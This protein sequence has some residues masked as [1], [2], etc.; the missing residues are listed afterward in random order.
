MGTIKNG[1]LEGRDYTKMN[2]NFKDKSL[3][4]A[5]KIME[6]IFVNLKQTEEEQQ[7]PKETAQ[8]I[9]KNQLDIMIMFNQNYLLSNKENINE[10]VPFLLELLNGLYVNQGQTSREI[11]KKNKSKISKLPAHVKPIDCEE[12][13]IEAP[14][15]NNLYREALQS[16]LLNKR[17]EPKGYMHTF[18]KNKQGYKSIVEINLIDTNE[19][20]ELTLEDLQV[21]GKIESMF[22][23][24]KEQVNKKYSDTYSLTIKKADYANLVNK[25]FKGVRLQKIFKCLDNLDKFKIE[26]TQYN[27]YDDTEVEEGEVLFRGRLLTYAICLSKTN[28]Y[29][30][31]F[32]FPLFEKM[33]ADNNINRYLKPSTYELSLK[34][35]LE[36]QIARKLSSMIYI[37]KK[38]LMNTN[39]KSGVHT[40]EIKYNSLLKDLNIEKDY[41]KGEA[42]NINKYLKRF[43]NRVIKALELIKE[44][45]LDKCIVPNVTKTTYEKN[46][47][48][49]AYN[50]TKTELLNDEKEA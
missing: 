47:I 34:E 5:N 36:Y 37:N 8:A 50:Y 31:T 21:L 3:E 49:V 44:L 20:I 19:D 12:K 24:Y 29:T 25:N 41:I 9:M 45:E 33:L 42:K 17:T 11:E 7:L 14:F 35:A 1:D 16:F 32:F 6:D 46:K 13:C 28:D 40:V 38:V 10:K 39:A 2:F 23:E 27:A 15:S 30:L 43:Q 4:E 48:V 26:I 22:L 18:K